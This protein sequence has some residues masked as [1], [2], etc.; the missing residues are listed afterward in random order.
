ML[1]LALGVQPSVEIGRVESSTYN[2]VYKFF[3]F[4]ESMTREEACLFLYLYI[5]SIYLFCLGGDYTKE[6]NEKWQSFKIQHIYDPR[7]GYR[8]STWLTMP[9]VPLPGV[10]IVFHT[11]AGLL[12]LCIKSL[13][14]K[15]GLQDTDDFSNAFFFVKGDPFADRFPVNI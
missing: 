7:E 11:P 1:G 14:E 13:T 8:Y 2:Y 5:K 9:D 12:T 4:F 10:G 6:E 15:V 3:D